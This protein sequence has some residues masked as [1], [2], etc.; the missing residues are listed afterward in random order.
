MQLRA[1]IEESTEVNF[2]S[3]IFKFSSTNS[4]KHLRKSKIYFYANF[5][6]CKAISMDNTLKREKQKIIIYS[7]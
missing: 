4:N 1:L 6:P 7:K 3:Q 2:E 5:I